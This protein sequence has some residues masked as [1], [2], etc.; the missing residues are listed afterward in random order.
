M[1]VLIHKQRSITFHKTAIFK[2]SPESKLI[3]IFSFHLWLLQS[4]FFHKGFLIKL[5]ALRGLLWRQKQQTGPCL[6]CYT[7]SYPTRWSSPERYIAL[8]S[9]PWI[10]HAHSSHTFH[11]I[12]PIIFEQHESWSSSLYNFLRS[13]SH[14]P[15]YEPIFPSALPSYVFPLLTPPP[16]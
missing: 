2:A 14:P 15:P 9:I 1:S 5:Y 7:A 3:L 4:S 10:W 12:T 6:P 13:P 16:K 11:F 8:P